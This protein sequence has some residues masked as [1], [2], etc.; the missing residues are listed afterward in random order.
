MTFLMF[1]AFMTQIGNLLADIAL[2]ILDP[3]IRIS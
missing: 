2:A 1:I 3:R